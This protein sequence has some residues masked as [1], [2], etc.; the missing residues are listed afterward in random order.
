MTRIFCDGCGSELGTLH[1]PVVLAGRR[2]NGSCGGGLPDGDFHLCLRCATIAFHALAVTTG[3]VDEHRLAAQIVDVKRRNR[4][5]ANARAVS[6]AA[7]V[8]AAGVRVAATG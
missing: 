2:A 7:D 3:P 8:G 5:A 4:A 1:S 6:R